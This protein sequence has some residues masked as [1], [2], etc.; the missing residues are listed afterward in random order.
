VI[1]LR[2]SAVI[3]AAT[4][5][6]GTA[7]PASAQMTVFAPSN[8]SQ[9]VLTAARTLQQINNQILSLQ[10]EAQMLINQARNLV[11]LPYS[12]L[13]QLQ[14]A[15]ELIATLRRSLNLFPSS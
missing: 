14:Q 7:L 9:N 8:F 12:S 5:V 1:R 2:L 15:A 6:A 13:Q 11:S 4:I 3:V 10:N